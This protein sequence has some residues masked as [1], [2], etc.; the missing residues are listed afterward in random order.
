MNS[1]TQ[2]KKP[3]AETPKPSWSKPRV[4]TGERYASHI[5]HGIPK[6]QMN[7]P[8][9]SHDQNITSNYGQGRDLS[10]Q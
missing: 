7:S 10:F 8:H 6:Y 4:N 9:S 5:W 3:Q 2:L 1:S